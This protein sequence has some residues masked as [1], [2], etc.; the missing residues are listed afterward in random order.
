MAFESKTTL[1]G[2]DTYIITCVGR[3]DT[4]TSPRLETVVKQIL[5]KKPNLL[6][7]DLERVDYMSSAGVRVLFLAQKGMKENGAK[8]A[9]LNIQPPVKKVLEI[10]NALPNQKIFKDM[11]ELDRYLDAIQ[12]KVRGEDD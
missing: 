8:L 10:I 6:A 7:L 9:L 3:L 12:K 4:E 2:S 1:K 5:Q 11:D